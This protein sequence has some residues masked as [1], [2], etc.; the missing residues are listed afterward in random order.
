MPSFATLTGQV[1]RFCPSTAPFCKVSDTPRPSLSS[2]PSSPAASFYKFPV[3]KRKTLCKQKKKPFFFF[4]FSFRQKKFGPRARWVPYSNTGK[5]GP[6][7]ACI[8][9]II[10]NFFFFY[11]FGFRTVK[12]RSCDDLLQDADD[13]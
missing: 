8:Y 1:T 4:I 11:W 9:Q 10:T 6:R 13:N 5:L 2:K 7:A 12:S 3:V